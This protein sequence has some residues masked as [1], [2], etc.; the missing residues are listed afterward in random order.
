MSPVFLEMIYMLPEH[1]RLVQVMMFKLNDEAPDYPKSRAFIDNMKDSVKGKILNY[2]VMT[3]EFM[4]SEK[5]RDI[6]AEEEDNIT[7]H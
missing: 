7:V 1:N 3:E 6:V 5:Y 4:D 2:R